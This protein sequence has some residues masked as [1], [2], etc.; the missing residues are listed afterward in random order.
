MSQALASTMNEQMLEIVE[1][2]VAAG[3]KMPIDLDDLAHFAIKNGHWKK[4]GSTPLQLCKRDFARAL[5]EQYHTDAQGRQ[6]RTYH[7]AKKKQQVFWAD[8]RD[9]PPEHMELAF[10][11]R[12]NQIVGDC[13]QLKQDVDS[14]NDNNRHGA[15]YQLTLDFGEDIAEREQPVDYRPRRPR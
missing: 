5:R 9:A 14:F 4:H 10:Q 3:G 1:L 12:R 2:Y 7:A 13:W 11:Q 8:M 6:V 15:S